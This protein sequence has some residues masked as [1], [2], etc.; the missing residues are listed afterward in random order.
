MKNP[1]DRNVQNFD[2]KQTARRQNMTPRFKKDAQDCR[3][4]KSVQEIYSSKRTDLQKVSRLL[5][6]S[7]G[8]TDVH[9]PDQGA[10]PGQLRPAGC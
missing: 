2:G 7:P 10:E 1:V 6:Y 4:Q 9:T 5:E 8:H 3:C